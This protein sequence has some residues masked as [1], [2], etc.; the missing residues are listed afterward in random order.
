MPW[1]PNLFRDQLFSSTSPGISIFSR[2]D[3]PQPALDEV[4]ADVKLNLILIEVIVIG[5]ELIILLEQRHYVYEYAF[6]TQF[7]FSWISALGIFS[8]FRQFFSCKFE[9]K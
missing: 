1:N 2:L 3:N 4:S 9:W 8:D 5:G 6:G 7:Y